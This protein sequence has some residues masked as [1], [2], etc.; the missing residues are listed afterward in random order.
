[1]RTNKHQP[2]TLDERRQIIALREQGLSYP[3][4]AKEMG[5]GRV[6]AGRWVRRYKAEG[7]AGLLT[8]PRRAPV[9][10]NNALPAGVRAEIIRLRHEH[11]E[12]TQRSIADEVSVLRYPDG[13][14]AVAAVTVRKALINAGLYETKGSTIV[15]AASDSPASDKTSA[16]YICD[17]VSDQ[18][19]IKAA[20]QDLP[21]GGR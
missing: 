9:R 14:K 8:K 4:I 7:E 5:I 1:M 10:P 12:W 3:K 17:G 11:P 19:E 2:L 21:G 16:D 18:E 13:S 6:T 15:I 20:L